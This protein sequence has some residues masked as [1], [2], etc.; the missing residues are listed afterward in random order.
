MSVPSEAPRSINWSYTYRCNFNCSHCYSRAPSYPAE[1]S[2]QQYATVTDRLLEAQVFNV[3]FGGGEP[4]V[5]R[6]FLATLAR[7]GAGGVF[8]HFTTNGW[9]VDQAMAERLGSA[10]LGMISISID[11]ANAAE[12]DRIR[13]RVGSFDKAVAAIGFM[14][15]NADQVTVSATVSKFNLAEIDALIALCLERGADQINL[16]VFRPAGNGL[17]LQQELELSEAEGR[18]VADVAAKWN[19]LRPNSVTLYGPES[20]KGCS[21]GVTT[22][23]IRP[24]GD[25]AMCPYGTTVIGNLINHDLR[26]IW[27]E[28]PELH[29]RR[30]V[31]D[32]CIGK[33]KNEFPMAGTESVDRK[34]KYVSV[35]RRRWEKEAVS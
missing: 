23:T 10:S 18:S 31:P 5:R 6:D 35:I 33:Q 7:L 24:N 2:E 25:V 1:L 9:Y 32:V 13:H 11:S 15:G 34:T 17:V 29:A 30:L 19:A 27:S 14:K 12:H 8:T 3:G 20:E 21:C 4:L 28:S 22:L 16:K 26:Q